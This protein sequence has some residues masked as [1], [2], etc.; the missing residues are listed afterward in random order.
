MPTSSQISHCRPRATATTSSDLAAVRRLYEL[1]LDDRV[2]EVRALLDPGIEWIEPE[3]APDRRVVTGG[4]AAI[5]AMTAWQEAWTAYELEVVD[6]IEGSGDCVFVRIRQRGVGATSGI[7]F[8]G[9][10]F[11]IWTLRDGVP[12]RMEMFFDGDKARR[13]AGLAS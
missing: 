2:E 12:F 4:D 7:P 9:D 8:E 5:E 6:M 10:L 13:A 3:E 1:Y 11:M